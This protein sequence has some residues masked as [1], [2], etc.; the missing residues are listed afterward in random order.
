[1]HPLS[2][3]PHIFISYA[4]SDGE[5]FAGQLRRR[6]T[7]EY[8]FT[9]WQDRTE[10]QVGEAWWQQIV[11]ALTNEHVEYMILVILNLTDNFI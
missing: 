4:R 8:G 6:L 10:M 5:D 1:M 3:P 7:K 11:A 9:V 2:S